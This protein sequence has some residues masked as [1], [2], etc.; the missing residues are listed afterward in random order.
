M[1]LTAHDDRLHLAPIPPTPQRILEC[2]TGTGIWAMEMGDR[3]PS[4]E[5]VGV[6]ITATAPAHV[7]P[8]VRF[9]I[10][11]L[12]DVWTWSAPFEYVHSRYMTGAIKDW[13]R[14]V[15]QCYE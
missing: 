6:D 14:Y 3:Y 5:I 12:E 4:A 9:E 13:E 15:R 11:D 7:P 2:G 8:N 1:L 10:D